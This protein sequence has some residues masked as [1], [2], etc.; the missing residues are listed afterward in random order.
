LQLLFREL[1]SEKVFMLFRGEGV[2]LAAPESN[3]VVPSSRCDSWK[4]SRSLLILQTSL[5]AVE[6]QEELYNAI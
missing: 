3:M 1:F 4:I 2:D 6:W 5:L